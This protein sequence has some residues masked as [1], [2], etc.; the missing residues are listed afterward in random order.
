VAPT[1]EVCD[2]IDNDQNGTVD[3][4]ISY[5]P[6]SGFATQC[7][8]GSI[9]SLACHPNTADVDHV[10]ANGCEID[11]S[12][13]PLNCGVLGN[14]VHTGVKHM[15]FYCVNGAATRAGGCDRGYADYNQVYYDGCEMGPDRY[16]PNDT[17]ASA[18]ILPWDSYDN[19]SLASIGERDY[20]S[21]NP[22]TCSEFNVCGVHFDVSSPDG[23]VMD[24]FRDGAQVA[25]GVPVWLETGMTE[26]HNFVIL[27]R[28]GTFPTGS[29]DGGLEPGAAYRLDATTT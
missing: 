25:S 26:S 24:V 14:N 15:A 22:G 19:L 13:D 12:T 29:G 21:F 2:G 23:A 11:L 18:R 6:F 16:E 9:M 10:V 27:V 7:V 20:Y 1:P 8:A 28:A 17:F 4:N 3:D 5:P